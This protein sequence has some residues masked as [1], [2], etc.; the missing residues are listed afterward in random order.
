MKKLLIIV[1]LILGGIYGC[2]PEAEKA[3]D[4]KKDEIKVERI[5]ESEIQNLIRRYNELL[6]AA[7]VIN[8]TKAMKEVITADH[9]ARL[10]HRLSNIEKAKRQMRA[11]LKEIEF[12]EIRYPDDRSVTANTKEVWDIKHIDLNTQEVIK[13]HSGYVYGLQYRILSQGNTWLIDS[14]EVISENVSN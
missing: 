4:I 8:D 14:V 5:T 3:A 9:D 12:L 2:S 10:Y 11:E 13:E 1:L 6:A 7:Y